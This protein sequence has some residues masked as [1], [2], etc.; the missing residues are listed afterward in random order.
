MSK[1]RSAIAIGTAVMLGLTGCHRRALTAHDFPSRVAPP[2]GLDRLVGGDPLT[3]AQAAMKTVRF[4]SS[5]RPSGV[6]VKLMFEH[7]RLGDVVL[8]LDNCAGISEMLTALWGASDHAAPVGDPNEIWASEAT[9]WVASLRHRSLQGGCV[10]SFTPSAFF[11]KTITP[12]RPLS[13]TLLGATRQRV[14]ELAPALSGTHLKELGA[15]ADAWLGLGFRPGDA[16]VQT[17]DLLIPKSASIAMKMA[18]GQGVRYPLRPTTIWVDPESGLRATGNEDVP[19]YDYHVRFDHYVPLTKWLGPG[20]ALAVLPS[21][22]LGKQWEEVAEAYGEA[23]QPGFHSL[24]LPPFE[25]SDQS[26]EQVVLS[27]DENHV[28]SSL[29]FEIPYSD[30]NMKESHLRLLESKWGL[31]EGSEPEWSFPSADGVVVRVADFAKLHALSVRIA[32]P[33][34]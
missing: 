34:D 33:R 23:V 10:L 27:S 12:P 6:E 21:P 15:I 20:E 22:V 8:E 24:F 17:E 5:S 32:L 7:D 16:R 14:T 26:E 9:G 25:S 13:P 30:D 11:G 3:K 28:I 1:L 18:W 31:R 19:D 29:D 4:D 2:F